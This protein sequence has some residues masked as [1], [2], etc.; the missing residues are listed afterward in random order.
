MK[1]KG[2]KSLLREKRRDK[3]ITTKR[4]FKKKISIRN[5]LQ[6]YLKSLEFEKNNSWKLIS[7]RFIESKV[8]NRDFYFIYFHSF[9]F[10]SKEPQFKI[11]NIVPN[12]KKNRY[13]HQKWIFIPLYS[14]C[15]SMNQKFKYKKSRTYFA[16]NR[17][18]T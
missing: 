1:R 2:N 6:N 9:I 8:I 4:I 16:G 7:N 13:Y 17:C 14:A 15:I 10:C 3:T 18:N 11:I 5:A 12:E